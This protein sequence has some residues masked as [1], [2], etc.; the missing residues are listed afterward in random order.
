MLYDIVE[1]QDCIPQLEAILQPDRSYKYNEVKSYCPYDNTGKNNTSLEQENIENELKNEELLCDSA[2][3]QECI[4]QLEAVLQ[5][6][7]LYI[8]EQVN[9][10][11][12]NNKDEDFEEFN[13]Y[14]EEEEENSQSEMRYEPYDVVEEQ[15]CIPELEAVLQLDGSYIYEVVKSCS[16][17]SNP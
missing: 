15:S 9:S 16:V 8:Y 3:D 4:P 14:E 11:F 5:K 17:N 13:Y 10:C 6:D 7:E 1:Q 2:E 12:S